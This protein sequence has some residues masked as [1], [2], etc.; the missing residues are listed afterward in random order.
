MRA[1]HSD[2]Q[3]LHELQRRHHQVRGAV[4]PGRLQ[5]EHNLTG[6]IALH[7]VA[8][9]R[10]ARDVAAQLFQRSAVLGAAAH[11]GVQA[12]TLHVGT[13]RLVEVRLPEHHALQRRAS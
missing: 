3:P 12:E 1:R 5:L 13:Q 6:R 4:A 2:R 9:Q 8:G 7:T 11:G 10:G